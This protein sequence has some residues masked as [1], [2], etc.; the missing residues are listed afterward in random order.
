MTTAWHN[1][2]DAD[3]DLLEEAID[4]STEFKEKLAIFQ[5]GLIP[6]E[7]RWLQLSA[8]HIY[9]Q[10]SERERIVFKMRTNQH[11]FPSIATKLDIS[12]SSAKTYWRRALNKCCQ[13]TDFI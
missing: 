6:T 3:A 12:A 13:L 10:L 7:M 4:Q 1:L 9:D 11:T 2:S 5:S 8:H